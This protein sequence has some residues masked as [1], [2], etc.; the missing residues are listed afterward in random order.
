MDA[1]KRYRVDTEKLQKAVAEE[2]A[3]KRGKAKAK[4]KRRKTAD[5]ISPSDF[6]AGAS[7][8]VFYLGDSPA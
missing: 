8:A 4:F 3:A 7:P 1:A 6:L 2:L 5:R